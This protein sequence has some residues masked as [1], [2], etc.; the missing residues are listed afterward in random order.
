MEKPIISKEKINPLLMTAVKTLGKTND[1]IG[2]EIG[3]SAMIFTQI[4]NLRNLVGF[5]TVALMR[6]KYQLNV[7]AIIDGDEQHLF[8]EYNFDSILAELEEGRRTNKELER[9]IVD[10]EAERD[11]FK[12]IA[13]QK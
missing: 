13:M 8:D 11:F 1:V 12:K 2:D 9:K 7:N 5:E 4:K 6:M 10:I 3:K